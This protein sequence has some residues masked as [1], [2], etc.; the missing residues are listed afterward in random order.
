MTRSTRYPISW[1]TWSSGRSSST[2]CVIWYRLGKHPIY[3]N[4]CKDWWPVVNQA[5]GK[6]KNN[7]VA[8]AP[9]LLRKEFHGI[10]GGGEQPDLKEF[11]EQLTTNYIGL[12]I[13]LQIT[14]NTLGTLD[15]TKA[16]GP[17]ELNNR[18]LKEARFHLGEV[19]ADLFNTSLRKLRPIAMWTIERH[20]NPKSDEPDQA[21]RM[22]IS[23]SH[24]VPGKSHAEDHREGHIASH[25]G[26]MA[27]ESSTIRS[28]HWTT[29][30]R[31]WSLKSKKTPSSSTSAK[32]STWWTTRGWCRN[33]KNCFHHTSHHE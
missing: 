27:E 20:L 12:N 11:K 10:C 17:D 31:F 2:E 4:L 7:E 6:T 25:R 8:I 29:K 21:K 32:R 3:R 33:S 23:L 16:V 22:Q 18:V 28:V 13:T 19:V 30:R 15:A 9:N 5:R 14:I 24:L 26:N 1:T